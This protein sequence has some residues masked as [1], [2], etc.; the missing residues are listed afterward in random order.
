MSAI[1]RAH[2]VAVPEPR[3]L[4]RAHVLMLVFATLPLWWLAGFFSFVWPIVGFFLL[5]ALIRQGDV[6]FPRGFGFWFLLVA[7][8]PLSVLALRGGNAPFL[9]AQRLAV[10]TAATVIFLYIFNSSRETLPDRTIVNA[11]TL[12]W[13]MLVVGGFIGM[14]FPT[15]SFKSPLEQLLPPGFVAHA[16]VQDLVHVNFAQVQTFLGYPVG[17]PSP[18]FRFTN[19]WGSGIALLTPIAV[20]GIGQAR[21]PLLRRLLVSLLVLSVVPIVVSLN[22]GVWLAL[23]VALAYAAVRF[24][25]ARRL[26]AIAALIGLA[27]VVLVLISLT[28]LGGLISQRFAHPHSN[29][30]RSELYHEAIDRTKESPLIGYGGPLAAEET[31]VNAPVGTHSEVFYLSISYGI[32]AVVFFTA[33]FGLTFLRSGRRAS[34]PRF[35]AHVAILIFLIEAPYYLL[36]MHVAVAMIIAAFIW[37][38]VA[39]PAAATEVAVTHTRARPATA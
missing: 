38:D 20:A 15:L 14:L 12:F 25:L 4:A 24:A 17:R 35:W 8:A 19:A 10:L 1:E 22:R 13:A 18:F 36:E 21:S 26:H 39:R 27:A 30:A 5:L 2:A 31:T 6:V 28:P 9:L 11:L 7:W 23:T 32:P 3:P 37:R 34:G 33:W 16:Y 29:E